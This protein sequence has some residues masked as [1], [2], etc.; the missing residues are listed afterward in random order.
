LIGIKTAVIITS[1]YKKKVQGA[2][3]KAKRGCIFKLLRQPMNSKMATE[4][5]KVLYGKCEQRVEP[6]L[7]QI[8]KR[9]FSQAPL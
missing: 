8:K 9:G 2:R 6:V 3:F 7:G 1:K 5:A 4:P